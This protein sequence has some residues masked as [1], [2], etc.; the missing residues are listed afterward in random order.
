[1][2][3]IISRTSTWWDEC[4]LEWCEKI[5]LSQHKKKTSF[6]SKEDFLY[7]QWFWKEE[8][9]SEWGKTQDWFIFAILKREKILW[10]LEI[11]NLKEFI[12]KNWYIILSEFDLEA[13]PEILDKNMLSLEIYDDY[14]E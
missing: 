4:P 5:I 3:Y 10:T 2:R 9:V 6:K 7:W 13:Y 1:M 11:E 12:E 14:R 8:D